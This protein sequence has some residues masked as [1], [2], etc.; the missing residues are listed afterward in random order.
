MECNIF[1]FLFQFKMDFELSDE[2]MTDITIKL[3]SLDEEL[4]NPWAVPDPSEFLQ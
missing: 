3:E 4:E 1:F 2:I